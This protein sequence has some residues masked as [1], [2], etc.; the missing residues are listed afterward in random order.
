MFIIKQAFTTLHMMYHEATACHVTG[1]LTEVLMILHNLLVCCRPHSNRPGT[2]YMPRVSSC[3]CVFVCLFFVV[4][5]VI[6]FKQGKLLN[7]VPLPSQRSW[8]DCYATRENLVEACVAKRLTPRTPDVEVR[9]S[10]LARRVVSL[11]RE[12]YSTLS[13][14]TQ[15]YKCVPATYCWA[16]TLQWTSIPSKGGVA[17]LLGMFHAKETGKLSCRLGLWLVCTFINSFF[18][19]Q[20]SPSP[21]RN[22]IPPAYSAN[23]TGPLLPNS[24][25]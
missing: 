2:V 18:S 17:I 15:V 25:L 24:C 20:T 13:L 11:D 14:F 16:V 10:S 5:D 9:G 7:Y 12:L 8:W 21:K 3:K 4:V 19:Y 22:S 1:D 6:F 23:Y